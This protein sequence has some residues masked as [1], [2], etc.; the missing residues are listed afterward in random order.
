MSIPILLSLGLLSS[1]FPAQEATLA[2]ATN[3]SIPARD[4]ALVRET[5]ELILKNS[6]RGTGSVLSISAAGVV[7]L[8]KIQDKEVKLAV[9]DVAGIWLIELPDTKP[10]KEPDRPFAAILTSDGSTLRGEIESLAEG[11][12]T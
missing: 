2:T 1:A 12:L 11:M 5:G 9:A 8:S 10:P 7:Y 3:S 4:V 6:D